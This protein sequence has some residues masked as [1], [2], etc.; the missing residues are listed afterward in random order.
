MVC[1]HS[2]YTWCKNG[3]KNPGEGGGREGDWGEGGKE[4]GERGGGR[5]GDWGEG[6]GEVGKETG[7]RGGGGREGDWHG[8]RGGGGGGK[9]TQL[10]FLLSGLKWSFEICMA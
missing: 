4:T 2:C 1:A 6:G 8:E 9:H 7:E 3:G 10:L 5:E